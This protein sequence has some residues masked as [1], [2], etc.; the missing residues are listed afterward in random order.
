MKKQK[1]EKCVSG[2]TCCWPDQAF[3]LLSGV[4]EDLSK[5]SEHDLI[6]Q[7]ARGMLAG[8]VFDWGAKEVALLMESES[9]LKFEDALKFVR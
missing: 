4:L 5:L 3:E 2:Y 7:L 8:N 1:Q 6:E 9:G